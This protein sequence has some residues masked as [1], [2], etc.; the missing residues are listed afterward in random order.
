MGATAVNPDATR[1]SLAGPSDATASRISILLASAVVA[2]AALALA[3]RVRIDPRYPDFIAGSLGLQAGSKFQDLVAVPA[4]LAGGIFGFWFFARV[5]AKLEA[6]LGWARAAEF[7]TQLI[8]WSIPAVAAGGELVINS[9]FDMRL[10][11]ASAA[12]LLLTALICNLTIRVPDALSPT[13]VSLA[14]LAGVLVALVP[15]EAAVLLGRAGGR[16]LSPDGFI[17]A[18]KALGGLLPPAIALA[19]I[20]R[21][22]LAGRWLPGLLALGQIG[23]PAFFF[24]LPPA[25]LMT[26]ADDVTAYSTTPGITAIAV[27]LAGWGVA[28]VLNRFRRGRRGLRSAVLLL[29]P[30][31]LLALVV[32][33][34]FGITAPP[35][36]PPDDYH[37]GEALLGWSSYGSDVIPYVDYTPQRG[38][39]ADDLIGS[40]S[41]VLYD[42]TAASIPDADRVTTALMTIVVFLALLLFTGSPGLAFV[43]TLFNGGGLLSWLF[44]VPFICLWSSPALR[45]EPA[46]WLSVWALTAPL[47]IL[48]APSLGLV[49]VA[50]SGILAALAVLELIRHPEKLRWLEIAGALALLA[51]ALIVTPLLPMLLGA[52][53]HVASNGPINQLAYGSE[54][55]LSWTAMPEG[56]PMELVRMS[57]AAIP[58]ACL[59]VVLTARRLRLTGVIGPAVVVALFS[60]LLI[61]YTM[62]RIDSGLGRPAL[63]AV[64][65]WTVLIPVVSWKVLSGAG[66]ALLLLSVAALGAAL[67]LPSLSLGYLRPSTLPAIPTIELHDGAAAGLP[68]IGVAGLED[69]HWERLLRLRDLMSATLGPDETYLDL[70]NRHAH[71][72]FL[73]RRPPIPVTAPFNLVPLSQQ[74]EAVRILSRNPPPIVLMEA[75]NIT[76]DGV[77]QALRTPLLYRFVLDNYLPTWTEGFI[78][79]HL[80]Q[81]DQPKNDTIRLPIGDRTDGAWDRGFNRVEPALSIDDSFPFQALSVGGEVQLAGATSRRITRVSP[82][83]RTV[84]LDGDP[85]DANQIEAPGDV[86]LVV[87]AG[88]AAYRFRM[89]LLDKAFAPADLALLPVAWGRSEESL[90]TRWHRVVS[91][92]PARALPG[93]QP[94]DT[95]NPGFRLDLSALEV[96]GDEASL[97]RFDLACLDRA[98]DPRLRVAWSGESEGVPDAAG[99][100]VFTGDDGTLI[101]PLAAYPRWSTLDAA[102]EITIRLDDAGACGSMRIE[103]AGLYQAEMFRS[104]K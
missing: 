87:E 5:K 91:L 38:M 83:E 98:A 25:R 55:S 71:Y 86:A 79:G 12:G 62:G 13:Q 88:P 93:A 97:L 64:F 42:G 14:I 4:F 92:S 31:A 94:D 48:G 49:L 75:D 11:L 43:S 10:V 77:A 58:L 36:L 18:A 67:N 34:R 99:E 90:S 35:H 6:E 32:V 21:P 33:L 26:P 23:L 29:S 52:I 8:W 95:A 73:G 61:P 15:V 101:V 9:T 54:W 80:E 22:G 16:N 60:L 20:V 3:L 1:G 96:G 24:T 102:R 63:L 103:N 41:G 7:A 57:W 81:D 84:W 65:G 56:L 70:T 89:A 59:A 28:D 37:F 68:R 47:V 2:S 30:I 27:A 46:R 50:A 53:G 82:E 51:A 17:L 76:H 39:V 69:A 100:L 45:R 44:L 104:Q 40:V 66:R 19:A 74:R 78:V 72:F 85:F